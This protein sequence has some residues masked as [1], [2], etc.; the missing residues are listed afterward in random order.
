MHWRLIKGKDW[1]ETSQC[2]CSSMSLMLVTAEVYV[3]HC[4]CG[5]EGC[6]WAHCRLAYMNIHDHFGPTC[7]GAVRVCTMLFWL[8]V[9]CQQNYCWA[10]SLDTFHLYT[11]PRMHR[12]NGLSPGE[13]ASS[14]VVPSILANDCGNQCFHHP[15]L[16][17]ATRMP[18]V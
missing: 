18:S 9:L 3:D 11:N 12:F 1:V 7:A 5:I 15:S 4:C 10:F 13:P 17:V 2:C 14:L 8:D 6:L 16:D